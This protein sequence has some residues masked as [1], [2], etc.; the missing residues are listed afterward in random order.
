MVRGANRRIE[1]GSAPGAGTR[2][3]LRVPARVADYE[4]EPGRWRWNLIGV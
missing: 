1:T 2:I 3:V 4:A